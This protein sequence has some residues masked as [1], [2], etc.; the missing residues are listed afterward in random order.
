[1]ETSTPERPSLRVGSLRAGGRG[2]SDHLLGEGGSGHAL[3]GGFDELAADSFMV[4]PP[5]WLCLDA[6]V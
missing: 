6:L 2:L 4:V 5:G 3:G 1:M